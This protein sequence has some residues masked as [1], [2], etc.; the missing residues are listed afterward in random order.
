MADFEVHHARKIFIGDNVD[1]GAE[2]LVGIE[3]VTTRAALVL[4]VVVEAVG[5]AEA[6]GP[7]AL[8]LD[9]GGVCA[10][11]GAEDETGG[12]QQSNDAFHV[13]SFLQ[14]RLQIK[15]DVT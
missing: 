13:R 8:G 14:M 11:E 9:V 15:P 4:V 1:L 12:Q 3:G 5:E 7:V 10:T 6:E 2:T